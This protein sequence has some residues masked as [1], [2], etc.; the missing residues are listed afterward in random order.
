MSAPTIIEAKTPLSETPATGVAQDGGNT[1]LSGKSYGQILKSST[2]VGGSSVVN[3]MVRIVQA[4]ANALLLGPTG[5]GLIG[6]FTS[7]TDMT[8]T[9]ANL[10]ISSSG[11]RQIAE[12]SGTGDATLIARTITTLRRVALLLGIVGALGLFFFRKWVAESTFKDAGHANDIGMLSLVV[13][14]LAVSGG[15]AALIQGLRRIGD[16]ARRSIYGVLLGTSLSVTIIY[17]YRE[18]GIVAA[19]IAIAATGIL[20]SWWYARKIQVEKVDLSWAQMWGE[21]RRL[22]TLGLA[23]AASGLM[24]SGVAYATRMMIVRRFGLPEAG[25][26]QS[27]SALSVVYVGFILQA[28]G[29][30]FYPRLTAAAKDNA[31]C[32]RMVNE[33]AEIGLLLAVPGILATLTFAPLVIAVFYSH[34]FGPASGVLRWQILGILLRVVSWPLA[35]IMLAKELK[36]TF[37]WTELISNGLHLA[38]TWICLRLW[39][40]PGAGIAFFLLYAFYTVLMSI[41]ARRITGFRWSEANKR[42]GRIMLPAVVIVF[43][44]FLFLPSV[45]AMV[46]GGAISIGI[47]IYN[48]KVLRSVAG[49]EGFEALNR[50]LRKFL[51]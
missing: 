5:V 40:L 47:G 18:R 42:L 7:I 39:G 20:T 16:L 31:L 1:G 41:L 50:K 30:D 4:K 35:F 26:Y 9:L 10:G 45:A 11:V 29:T 14:C 44:S 2:I 51:G 28:M 23:F 49:S 3:V 17:F 43:L 24:V 25:H 46:L 33:Q 15:Q 19:L 34:E 27:A 36:Q 38:V 37:F 12:A 8:G 22:L 32:N 6:V 21:T 13:L 48:L